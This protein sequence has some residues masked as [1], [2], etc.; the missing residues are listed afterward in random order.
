MSSPAHFRIVIVRPHAL[1]FEF[2]EV[3]PGLPLNGTVLPPS[4]NSLPLH[5]WHW[6]FSA[7]LAIG[8]GLNLPWGNGSGVVCARGRVMRAVGDLRIFFSLFNYFYISNTCN[9]NNGIKRFPKNRQHGESGEEEAAGLPQVHLP[10]W[11]P[12]P[13][14]GP[15]LGAA[16]KAALQSL[17]AMANHPAPLPQRK[18]LFCWSACTRPRRRCGPPRS[19]R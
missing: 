12:R 18:L 19:Q 5:P 6:L 11:G 16:A 14:G 15:I 10:W 4:S 3:P 2:C 1:S 13:A 9:G 7:T 17:A 8:L